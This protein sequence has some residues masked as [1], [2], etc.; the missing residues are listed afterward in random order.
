MFLRTELDVEDMGLQ[1][2]FPLQRTSS[3]PVG[4]KARGSLQQ[5]VLLRAHE[6]NAHSFIESAQPV[7]AVS[8]PPSKA[9]GEP[10]ALRETRL[11]RRHP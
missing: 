7:E 2:D 5:V 4:Q 3:T 1:P 8:V 10:G 6:S 9:G 11:Q